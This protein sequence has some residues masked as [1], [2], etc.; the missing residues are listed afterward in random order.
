[1][2]NGERVGS[3]AAAASVAQ[4]PSAAEAIVTAQNALHMVRRF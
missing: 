4:V 2:A 3:D 1:V